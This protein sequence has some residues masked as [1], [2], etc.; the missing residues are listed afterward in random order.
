[1]IASSVHRSSIEKY[2]GIFPD[3]R[4][5]CERAIREGRLRIIEDMP[6][7]ALPCQTPM[8]QA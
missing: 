1:M 3:D 8:T 7:E 2:L 5:K 4:Y 6:L